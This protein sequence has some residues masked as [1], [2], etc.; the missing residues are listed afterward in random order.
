[1]ASTTKIM[2]A[3]IA[4]EAGSLDETVVAGK[5]AAGVEGTS[6]YLSGR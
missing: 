3:L 4:L 1:M 2:T 6:I 5:N